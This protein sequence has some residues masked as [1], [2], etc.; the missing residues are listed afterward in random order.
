MVVQPV[1]SSPPKPRP[2]Q[3][4]RPVVA[5][6][7][8]TAYPVVMVLNVRPPVTAIGVRLVTVAPVPSWPELPGPCRQRSQCPAGEEK[9]D[10]A[11]WAPTLTVV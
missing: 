5:T 1:P 4:P 7:H 10:G 8:V 3:Y 11:W 2:Q 9:A 6:A